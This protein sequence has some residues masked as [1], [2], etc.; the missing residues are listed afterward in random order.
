MKKI[1][2]IPF[3]LLSLTGCTEYETITYTDIIVNKEIRSERDNV[4]TWWWDVPMNKQVYYFILKEYGEREATEEDYGKYK[5]GDTYSWE[6][7][8]PKKE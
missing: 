8:V 4:A 5:I 1:L 7:K 6:V 2:V 3:L